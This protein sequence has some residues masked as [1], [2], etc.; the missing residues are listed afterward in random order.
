MELPKTYGERIS[1]LEVQLKNM[2]TLYNKLKEDQ[3]R[4]HILLEQQAEENR[5]LREC[6]IGMKKDEYTRIFTEELQLRRVN[7]YRSFF[8]SENFMGSIQQA[9]GYWAF[10]TAQPLAGAELVNRFVMLYGSRLNNDITILRSKL[11]NYIAHIDENIRLELQ[12]AF[13]EA[14]L[15]ELRDL[16]VKVTEKRYALN[17]QKEDPNNQLYNALWQHIEP[18]LAGVEADGLESLLAEDVDVAKEQISRLLTGVQR[19]FEE[20]GI[21]VCY[22]PDALPRELQSEADDLF[23]QADAPGKQRPLIM[24]LRDHYIYTRGF[25]YQTTE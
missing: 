8:S 23:M 10:A 18:L 14:Q 16:D 22:S 15:P 5:E 1:Q 3:A 12:L 7:F 11:E 25:N 6:F 19:V 13:P 21:L 20:Q 9:M 4:D 17:I 24:R 2:F